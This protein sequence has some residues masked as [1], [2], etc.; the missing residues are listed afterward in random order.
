MRVLATTAVGRLSLR[1]NRLASEDLPELNSPAMATR[2]GRASRASRRPK[3]RTRC[4]KVDFAVDSSWMQVRCNADIILRVGAYSGP[5][6]PARTE[7][8]AWSTETGRPKARARKSVI[9]LARLVN[10]VPIRNKKLEL[11]TNEHV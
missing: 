11:S 1:S 10:L 3:A 2:N 5:A 6:S 8:G 9:G 7:F 4:G